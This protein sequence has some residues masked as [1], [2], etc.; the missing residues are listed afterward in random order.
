MAEPT[1]AQKA[2]CAV[3]LEAGKSY[4]WC[5]CGKSAAQPFCDGSHAGSEFRPL[6]FEAAQSKTAHLCGC[7]HTGNP[8]YCDGSHAKL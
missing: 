4:C 6:K 7:K 2:P 3:Q 5:A 1:M 8:P